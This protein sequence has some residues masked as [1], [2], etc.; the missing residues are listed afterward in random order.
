MVAHQRANSN[1]TLSTIITKFKVEL[2]IQNLL[3]GPD[4]VGSVLEAEWE[5]AV[6][7]SELSLVELVPYD[8]DANLKRRARMLAVD[9]WV[10]HWTRRMIRYA[11]EKR[12]PYLGLLVRYPKFRVQ[13]S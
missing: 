9:G 10:D 7:E 3:V 6:R 11:L 1:L 8:I 13:S 12:H 5:A 2:I 4:A